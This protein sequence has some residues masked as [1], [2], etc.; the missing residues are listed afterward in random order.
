MVAGKDIGVWVKELE[1][2][3]RMLWWDEQGE[4][5]WEW[6]LEPIDPQTTR[7][8]QRLRVT[9]HPWTRRM[10]YELVAANGD[11][12]MQR[13]L[14]RGIKQRAERLAAHHRNP[15]QKPVRP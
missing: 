9:R 8:L 13:K 5:S 3:R 1:P 14:L 2:E 12:V 11:V 7:L 4:Y 10:L 15:G 6:L